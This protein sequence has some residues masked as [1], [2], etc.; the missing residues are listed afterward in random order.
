M[1]QFQAE[2]RERVAAALTSLR[3]AREAGD[4]HLAEIRVGELES[5]ARLARDHDIP[6]DE[7]GA[8]NPTEAVAG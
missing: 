8:Y 4:D 7:L 2:L 1:T 3:E 6:V 5:L